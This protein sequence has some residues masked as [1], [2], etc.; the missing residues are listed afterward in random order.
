M[1]ICAHLDLSV[2]SQNWGGAA[3]IPACLSRMEALCKCMSIGTA[4]L[5]KKTGIDQI[6]EAIEDQ[7]SPARSAAG[8]GQ[9]ACIE[10]DEAV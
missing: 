9:L 10:R 6:H 2:L 7:T 4:A 8:K 3:A 5:A 1:M